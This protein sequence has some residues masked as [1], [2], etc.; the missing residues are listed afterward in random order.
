MIEILP[1]SQGNIMGIKASGRLTAQDYE[2]ILI[3]KIEEVLKNNERARFLYYI[4]DDLEG[5]E[6]G[7]MWDDA[8]FASGHRDRFDKIAI[9]TDSKWMQWSSKLVSYFLQGEVKSFPG[10]QLDEAWIW[11]EA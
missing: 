6:P 2:E 4:S 9:V 11:I 10:D 3:P 1:K 8:K 5:I 7:A